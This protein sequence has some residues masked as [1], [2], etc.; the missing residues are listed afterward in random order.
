MAG[1]K[2]AELIKA[3]NLANM[4]I[5]VGILLVI[6][7]IGLAFITVV[8]MNDYSYSYI[9]QTL[10]WTHTVAVALLPLGITLTI[11]S[12][13]WLLSVKKRMQNL[14][15]SAEEDEEKEQHGG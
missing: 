2:K 9:R 10:G 5:S 1:N 13:V 7:P 3:A 4:M 11:F 14:D 8:T 6:V 15:L 12:L